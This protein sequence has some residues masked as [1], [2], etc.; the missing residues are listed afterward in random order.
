MFQLDESHIDTH[1]HCET[2]AFSL[3][4]ALAKDFGLWIPFLNQNVKP[5]THTQPLQ[6]YLKNNAG[7]VQAGVVRKLRGKREKIKQNLF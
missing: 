2:A 6:R 5:A 3:Q 1:T 4:L 7:G